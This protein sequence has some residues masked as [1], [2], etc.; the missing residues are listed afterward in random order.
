MTKEITIY[1]LI[2]DNCGKDSNEHSEYSGW[3]E[4]DFVKQQAD[5]DGWISEEDK[6]YCP[7]CFSYDDN[8]I[9]VIKTINQTQ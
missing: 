7:S 3:D 9:L 1:T 4:I 6:D 8:D 5:E 2:C